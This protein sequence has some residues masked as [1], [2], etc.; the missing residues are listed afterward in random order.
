MT[1]G[2]YSPGKGV[3][4]KQNLAT[5]LR[6]AAVKSIA[7][8]FRSPFILFFLPSLPVTHCLPVHES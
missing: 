5:P 3:D 6:K 7:K 1:I 4:L 2:I 8:S